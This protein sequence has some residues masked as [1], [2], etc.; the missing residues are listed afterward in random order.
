M[1]FRSSTIIAIRSYWNYL[2]EEKQKK[3]LKEVSDIITVLL[4]DKEE[5]LKPLV[6]A[7]IQI[8]KNDNP[9]VLWMLGLCYVNGVGVAQDSRKAIDL[10][11]KAASQEH[12]VAQNM[13]GEC[14]R[15]GNHVQKDLARAFNLFQMAVKQKLPDAFCNLGL[16]YENG[17]GV[18]IDLK[19]ADEFYAM[20]LEKEHPEAQVRLAYRYYYGKGLKKD[21]TKAVDLLRK[22]ADQRHPSAQHLLGLYYVYGDYDTP[23]DLTKGIDLLQKAVEE[24]HTGAEYDLGRLYFEGVGVSKDPQKAIVLFRQAAAKNHSKALL[25]LGVCYEKAKD[26]KRAF[27][28]YQRGAD[29]NIAKAQEKLGRFYFNGLAGIEKNLPLAAKLFKQAAKNGNAAAQIQLGIF[30][31]SG[32][33]FKQDNHKAFEI[34]KKLVDT[35]YS[36]AYFFLAVCYYQGTGIEQDL[37][38]AA[39]LTQQAAEFEKENPTNLEQLIQTNLT[40]F[41][42]DGLGVAQDYKRAMILQVN[43]GIQ[44]EVFET[45]RKRNSENNTNHSILGFCYHLGL[46]VQKDLYKACTYYGMANEKDNRACLWDLY[47]CYCS[48]QNDKTHRETVNPEIFYKFYDRLKKLSSDDSNPELRKEA[49]DYLRHIYKYGGPYLNRD[50]RKAEEFRR[51]RVS[52][53]QIKVSEV[54]E[55]PE[56]EDGSNSETKAII[57]STL[58]PSATPAAV[59]GPSTG[60]AAFATTAVAATGGA[61]TRNPVGNSPR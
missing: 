21:L 26:L 28:C 39:E 20:A 61:S 11:Q 55:V 29:L 10:L 42:N 48:M 15:I 45:F 57:I 25:S 47:L 9:D 41:Y 13:L 34:F 17:Q 40:R 18:A 1:K 37:K 52:E 22:I 56:A 50:L 38:R 16:Y 53:S 19:R 54:P 59:I 24:G 60:V 7:L 3:L 4:S 5:D 58:N 35:G 30:Y 32:R 12:P 6:T 14:Y 46:G 33:V 51:M 43:P 8:E 31:Q 27:R 49:I 44:S 2:G 23:K 36:H